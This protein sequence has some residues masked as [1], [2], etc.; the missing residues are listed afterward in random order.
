[1]ITIK[2]DT[3]ISSN[4]NFYAQCESTVHEAVGLLRWTEDD[5]SLTLE[6][7]IDESLPLGN[8]KVSH[9]NK[10]HVI[11]IHPR[12]ERSFPWNTVR[13]ETLHS[14]LKEMVPILNFEKECNISLPE[15]YRGQS[16][17]ENL[18]EY[19]VRCLN[20]IQISKTE[21]K[22]WYRDQIQHDQKSGFN[23][24]AEV[25]SLVERWYNQ[26]LPFGESTFVMI[27]DELNKKARVD[28]GI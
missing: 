3:V 8:G 24:I 17:R 4:K 7:Q 9:D 21:G 19:I 5:C 16:F 1:M 27:I 14:L 13:H 20:A 26:S 2:L 23:R 18:E 15:D 12:P 11:R 22:I 6:V 28:P 25:S 10:T